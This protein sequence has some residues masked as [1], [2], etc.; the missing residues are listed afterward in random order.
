MSTPAQVSPEAEVEAATAVAV[1]ADADTAAVAETD[2]DT[3]VLTPA[4]S[5][6]SPSCEGLL[7]SLHLVVSLEAEFEGACCQFFCFSPEYLFCLFISVFVCVFATL[8]VLT[9]VVQFDVRRCL[10]TYH[11]T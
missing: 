3:E 2:A 6:A 4:P 8:W 11:K 10:V 9:Y 1:E 7:F 5:L